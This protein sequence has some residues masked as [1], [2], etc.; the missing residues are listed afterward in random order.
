MKNGALRANESEYPPRKIPWVIGL[1]LLLFPSGCHGGGLNA[2]ALGL[3]EGDVLFQT[4]RSTQSQAIQLATHSRWS[5]MGMLVREKKGW[6]VLEAVQPVKFTPLHEWV[7]RGQGGHVVIKRLLEADRRLDAETLVRMRKAGKRFL[8]KPYD[9]TFEWGDQ[10]IYCSELVWKIYKEGAGIE[11]GRLQRLKDFDLSHSAVQK[12]M[13][14]RYGNKVPIEEPVISP[15]AI[16][17][18]PLLTTVVER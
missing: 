8:G 1:F 15:K 16:F 12:K 17:E 13:R 2:V 7:E 6:M 10:R 9:S 4:S 11:L 3:K 14:E 18:C 5:H